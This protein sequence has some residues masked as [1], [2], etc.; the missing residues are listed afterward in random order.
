MM[1]DPVQRLRNI[2]G[3][4]RLYGTPE[5]DL[6][7]R[8]IE[9]LCDGFRA[10]LAERDAEIER[11]RAERDALRMALVQIKAHCVGNMR[12]NWSGGEE[13]YRSRAWIADVCDAAMSQKG[14]M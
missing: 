7:A 13:T 10:R 14:S 9:A 4:I 6:A 8:R 5:P 1:D 11:L 12:P 3:G 2:A